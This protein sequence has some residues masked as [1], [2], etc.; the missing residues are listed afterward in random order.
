MYCPGASRPSLRASGGLPALVSGCWRLRRESRSWRFAPPLILQFMVAQARACGGTTIDWLV[1]NDKLTKGGL[2]NSS[3]TVSTAMTLVREGNDV[4]PPV[5]AATR[6]PA[7][8]LS[9]C[10]LVPGLCA[11]RG[12]RSAPV[13]QFMCR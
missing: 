1:G 8:L 4:R 10:G 11:G 12:L 3:M 13:I 7:Q 9:G 5:R 2:L 6:H